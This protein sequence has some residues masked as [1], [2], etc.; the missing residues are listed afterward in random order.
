MII[1]KDEQKKLMELFFVKY[2]KGLMPKKIEIST[3][4]FTELVEMFKKI[5]NDKI[6]I[7]KRGAYIDIYTLSGTID[8]RLRSDLAPF[9]TMV[10]V[11]FAFEPK[12]QGIGTKFLHWLKDFSV[13]RGFQR[14]MIENCNTE[15]S[16]SFATKH[17]FLPL[18][19]QTVSGLD[20]DF[21]KSYEMY[22]DATL[23]KQIR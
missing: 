6:M 17:G 16:I 7:E 14:L 22:L 10:I 18:Y 19:Q 21:G 5:T 20:F 9:P 8:V 11:G 13:Q 12:R 4:D 3:N 2:E 1:N 23:V 15:A